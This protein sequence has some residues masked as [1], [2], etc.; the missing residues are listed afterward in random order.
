MKTFAI[1]GSWNQIKGKLQ[2]KFAQLTDDD[3]SFV[4]GKTEELFGRLQTKLGLSLSELYVLLNDLKASLNGNKVWD[5]ISQVKNTAAGFVDEIRDKAT[6]YADD[7][8]ATASMKTGELKSQAEKVYKIARQRADHLHRTLKNR[9]RR[10]PRQSLLAALA[11][12]F[13]VGLMVRR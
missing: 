7:V 8:R 9:V 3:M 11:A 5:K 1:D 12:G 6:H 13:V 2:Q 4:E 10:K